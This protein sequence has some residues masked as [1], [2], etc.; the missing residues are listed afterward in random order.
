M[1]VKPLLEEVSL[2]RFV[3][4]FLF[5]PLEAVLKKGNMRNLLPQNDVPNLFHYQ[6]HE[7]HLAS[8]FW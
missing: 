2:Y 8:M 1:K 3:D 6:A 7:S 4:S 5:S